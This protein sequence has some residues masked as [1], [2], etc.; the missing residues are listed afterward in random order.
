V[1]NAD[2]ASVVMAS[3]YLGKPLPERVAGIDLMQDLVGLSEK[4]GY[5]IY[6][7]GAKQEIVEKTAKVL[8]TR[9]PSLKIVGV[10]DGYFNE[11]EW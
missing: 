4:K 6:L 9:Y 2:G 7:L 11:T 8:M 10:H 3:K 5:S 1:I